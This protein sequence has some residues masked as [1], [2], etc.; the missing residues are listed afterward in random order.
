M[1]LSAKRPLDQ[2]FRLMAETAEPCSN[3]LSEQVGLFYSGEVSA[4]RHFGPALH[5]EK[6]L[7]PFPRRMTDIFRKESERCGNFA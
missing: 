6:P 1:K 4:F 3:V 2:Q 5:I 7:C